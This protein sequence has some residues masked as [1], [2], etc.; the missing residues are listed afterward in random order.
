[1]FS[2]LICSVIDCI[3]RRRIV[4]WISFG[5]AIRWILEAAF[6]RC[7]SYR[8]SIEKYSF[9]EILDAYG[10]SEIAHKKRENLHRLASPIEVPR[11]SDGDKVKPHKEL[12]LI[13]SDYSVRYI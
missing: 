4:L 5:K 7:I 10:K 12:F 6:K 9:A 2:V 1:I 11:I 13:L 3:Q 8:I